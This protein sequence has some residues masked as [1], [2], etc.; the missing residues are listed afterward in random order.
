[1]GSGASWGC[2]VVLQGCV[3]PPCSRP[4]PGCGRSWHPPGTPS[5][6]SAPRLCW[7]RPTCRRWAQHRDVP[8]VHAGDELGGSALARLSLDTTPTLWGC[9]GS[10]G[11]G[12]S[13]TSQSAAQTRAEHGSAP[14]CHAPASCSS[15]PAP[16]LSLSVPTDA[17]SPPASQ[18]PPALAQL[19]GSGAWSSILMALG[20]GQQ[21]RVRRHA[22]CGTCTA[23]AQLGA[24]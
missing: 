8:R 18:T 11:P 10:C 12:G 7:S 13:A 17:P 19:G 5:S 21:R 1:M 22:V 3:C 9:S 20:K 24:P 14:P 16:Q 6:G 4:V 15:D 2:S 23:L